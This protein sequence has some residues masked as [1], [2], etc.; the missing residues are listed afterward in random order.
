MRFSLIL[1]ATAAASGATVASLKADFRLLSARNDRGFAA[2]AATRSE[3]QDM[4]SA[5]EAVSSVGDEPFAPTA[6]P[7]LPGK[8]VLFSNKTV[9]NS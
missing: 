7:R 8:W 3:L 6:D 5:I 1:L 9:L 2:S 4:A